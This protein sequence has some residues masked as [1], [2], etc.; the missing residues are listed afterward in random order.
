MAMAGPAGRGRGAS[1]ALHLMPCD[2]GPARNSRVEQQQHHRTAYTHA[3]HLSCSAT[4]PF[5]TSLR[6]FNTLRNLCALSVRSSIAP[7]RKSSSTISR[8][9]FSLVVVVL[10]DDADFVFLLLVGDAAASA[11][12]PLPDFCGLGTWEGAAR[13][14]GCEDQASKAMLCCLSKERRT[15]SS[16]CRADSRGVREGTGATC[17]VEGSAIE[18][19]ERVVDMAGLQGTLR[20]VWER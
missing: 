17:D 7:S 1:S 12:V 18:P 2:A 4:H 20:V 8:P 9:N 19:R 13:D 6:T 5:K 3:A 15:K 16:W 11:T 14:E 10:V